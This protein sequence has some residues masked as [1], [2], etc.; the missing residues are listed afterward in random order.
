MK[1]QNSEKRKIKKPLK[2]LIIV[3]SVIAAIALIAGSVFLIMYQKGKNDIKN[4]KI[5]KPILPPE[6]L[7]EEVKTEQDGETVYYKGEKYKYNENAVP[8]LLLGIDK[9]D[10]DDA[11]GIG[12]NGQA[13]AVYLAVLNTETKEVSILTVSRDSMVDVDMYSEEGHFLRSEKMQLCLSYAYGDGKEK[14]CENTAKSVSRLL[15]NIP[16]KNY[17]AIDFSALPVLNDM[18]GGVTVPEYAD[19]MMTKTGNSITLYGDETIR[20][21]RR[22]NIHFAESN[23]VRIERQKS[24]ITAFTKKAVE[25]TKKDITLP[26]TLFSSISDYTVTNVG[27]SQITYMAANYLEGVSDMKMHTVPGKSEL[28]GEY[29][30]FTADNTLL[31][32]KV[33][34]LFYVKQ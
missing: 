10:F 31:Y 22:R 32:E 8:I 20:Y 15:F 24:F 23:N 33:L 12:F 26:I 28:V 29:Y 27:A 14:S 13:D 3:L 7:E 2:I 17:I 9:Y 6:E 16:I 21:L 18:V 25:M 5:D 4:G 19:D 1:K 11:E 34:E 30:Q